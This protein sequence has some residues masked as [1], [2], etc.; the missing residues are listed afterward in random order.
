MSY[1]T[2]CSGA[3][4]YGNYFPALAGGDGGSGG[5]GGLPGNGE[6]VDF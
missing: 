6:M 5:D 1:G 2:W 4:T 3:S